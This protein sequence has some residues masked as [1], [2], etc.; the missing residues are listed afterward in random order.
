MG[1]W[2]NIASRPDF[3]T[4]ICRNIFN[5]TTNTNLQLIQYK[6]FHRA[7]ITQ[8]K[9]FKMGL[10]D[11]DTCSQYTSGSTDYFHATWL[12]Q[13]VH[14]LWTTVTNTLSSALDFRFPLSPALC[15]LGDTSDTAFPSKYK[16]PVSLAIAKKIVFQNWKSSCHFYHWT[17]QITEF[18]LTEETAA[19]QKNNISGFK[20]TWNPLITFLQV[21]QQM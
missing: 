10:S 12:C 8:S 21:Q 15:L 19:H 18:I 9:T 5:M 14:S 11:T 17:N 13:P 1:K 20:E 6:T 2:P 16:T 4:H 3:W 7:H